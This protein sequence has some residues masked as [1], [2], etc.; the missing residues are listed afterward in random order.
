MEYIELKSVG[1][2]VT[3]LGD[4]YPCTG[5]MISWILILVGMRVVKYTVSM[6]NGKKRLKV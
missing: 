6:N 3:N 5:E 4:V 2:L 1:S